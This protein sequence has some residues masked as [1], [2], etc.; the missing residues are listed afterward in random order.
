[1]EVSR[2]D[3][4]RLRTGVPTSS[5]GRRF[6]LFRA[7]PGSGT[8]AIEHPRLEAPFGLAASGGKIEGSTPPCVR[9]DPNLFTREFAMSS[10]AMTVGL[11]VL[12]ILGARVPLPA[13][14]GAEPKE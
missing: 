9:L 4:Q 1:M 6:V 10:R 12:T 11:F 2:S 5:D 14:R 13:A 3:A 8:E 7:G